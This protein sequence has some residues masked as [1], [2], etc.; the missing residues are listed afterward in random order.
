MPEPTPAE[1]R[2]FSWIRQG[3]L[4]GL[5]AAPGTVDARLVVPV[6]VRLN[7]ARDI[8]VPLTLY[9][10]ADITG[11]DGREIIRTD[12]QP[13]ATDFEPNYFP[14][15]EFDRPDFPW[16]FTPAVPDGA[17][18]LD[19]WICLVVV[20]RTVATLKPN[21]GGALPALECPLDELPDLDEAWAWAHA[22]IVAGGATLPEPVRPDAVAE[23]LRSRPERTLSRLVGARRLDPA[24]AYYACVVPTHEVGRKTGLGD[25]VTAEDERANRRA[26]P[27]TPAD[28]P[29]TRQRLPVY[30]HWEFSTGAAG[31]FE[32]IARRLV[33]RQMPATVGLRPIDVS[34]PGWGM[35]QT[36]PEAA[37]SRLDLGGALQTTDTAP[38]PWPDEPRRRFQ[39]ALRRILDVAAAASDPTGDPAVLSPPLYGQWYVDQ[40]S[41]PAGEDSLHWFRE[42]NLDPRTRLAAGL[43]TLVVRFEQ[44]QLMAAAWDQ[45]ARRR[46]DNARLQR[47]QLAESVGGALVDKH[48][49]G[50]RADRLLRLTAPAHARLDGRGRT[51]GPAARVALPAASPAIS[52]TY[53]R[54]TRSSGPVARRMER[55]AIGTELARARA[56]RRRPMPAAAARPVD[57]LALT[58]AGGD[59]GRAAQ[60]RVLAQLNPQRAV[61]RALQAETPAVESTDLVRFAPEFLQPMYEPLRD[62][63]QGMLLPGIEHVPANTIALLETNQPF[64][65][66]YMIGL[67]HEMS[68]ELLWR[69]YPTDRRAT[70]FRQFWD[71]RGRPGAQT[72]AEREATVDIH[73]IASWADDSHLGEHAMRAAAEGQMVLLVRGDL[74]SRFPRAM[75]YAVEAVWSADGTR[76]EIGTNEQ[77]PMFRATQAPDIT[78]LGFQLTE[79]QV[80]GADSAANSGH[81][82]WHFILQEQ[83]TEPRFGLDVPTSF[84]GTPQHWRDATWGHLAT[85]QAALE[86]LRYVPIDGLLKDVALD[87][88]AWGRNSAQMAAITRQRPFRVAV[89]ARTWLSGGG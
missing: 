81:A 16:L 24:T 70:Y 28:G 35:P 40:S 13:R 80:R 31:D 89:H 32:S 4:A 34:R 7:E 53:R 8:D 51:S 36:D 57:R 69:G 44:E 45:L 5:G 71:V 72:E 11:V 1:Y 76:R 33:P 29:E 17:R 23:V 37:G 46:Q 22:Q 77:Y 26:W 54:L 61:L 62:Y 84:G 55:I 73:A 3:L 47:A 52:G 10:P 88:V 82:G 86:R 15:V 20:R 6:R 42:L 63:F 66:A 39:A 74:F 58:G 64:I 59:Q 67:N 38:A 56:D 30:F 83:P 9:G 25:P 2:V 41:V 21:G 12:P 79:T 43:G 19:P 75:V 85:D 18:R 27:A 49:T 60:A 65:E 68:R 14:I 48:F 78:M 87:G 50:L